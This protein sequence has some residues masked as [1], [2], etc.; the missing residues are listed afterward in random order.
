LV[1]IVKKNKDNEKKFNIYY[2]MKINMKKNDN[3]RLPILFENSPKGDFLFKLFLSSILWCFLCMSINLLYQGFDW[4]IVFHYLFITTVFPVFLCGICGLVIYIFI[5]LFCNSFHINFKIDNK[6]NLIVL[7]YVIIINTGSFIE[8][9]S[10][11][12]KKNILFEDLFPAT[13]IFGS[14]GFIIFIIFHAII[15]PILN[16]ILKSK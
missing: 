4:D 10:C 3:N 8:L 14:I 1:R 12:A 6:E 15:S 7:L 2:L 5:L 11:F 16:F 13:V 9:L